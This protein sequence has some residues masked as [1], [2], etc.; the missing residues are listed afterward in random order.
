MKRLNPRKLKTQT[1]PVVYDPRVF[2]LIKSFGAAAP[3]QGETR[4]AAS[5][6]KSFYPARL[7]GL[8]SK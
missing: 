8:P 2:P 1:V 5:L 4:H 3:V 7:H 6:P